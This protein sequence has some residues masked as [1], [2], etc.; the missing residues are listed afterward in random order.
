MKP[1]NGKRYDAVEVEVR[2]Q[3]KKDIAIQHGQG[4][5]VPALRLRLDT[6]EKAMGI[7]K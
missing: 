2:K 1:F 3:A 4:N 7:V 6:I 5:N